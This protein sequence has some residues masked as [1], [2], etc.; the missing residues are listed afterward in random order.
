VANAEHILERRKPQLVDERSMQRVRHV[1]G[2]GSGAERVLE[3]LRKHDVRSPHV[4]NGLTWTWQLKPAASTSRWL[5]SSEV[6]GLGVK[7]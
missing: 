5:M 4:H 6:T 2:L 7:N 3:H 1:W